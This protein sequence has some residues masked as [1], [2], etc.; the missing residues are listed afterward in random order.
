MTAERPGRNWLRMAPADFDRGAPAAPDVEDRHIPAVPDEYGTAPLFG[1]DP[2]TAGTPGTR[3]PAPT[4]PEQ[5][6][7]LF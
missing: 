6:D 7:T 4:S 3:A 1:E 2:T 5:P